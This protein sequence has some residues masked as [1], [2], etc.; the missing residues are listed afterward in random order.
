ME[1][2]N[3]INK[4]ENT[5]NNLTFWNF[6]FDNKGQEFYAICPYRVPGLSE[7]IK[8]VIKN[9]KIVGVEFNENHNLFSFILD[10]RPDEL[11]V[12]SNV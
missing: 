9:N 7:F 1:R 5:N 11:K 8:D 2:E 12:K 10:K 6:S 3:K 4:M